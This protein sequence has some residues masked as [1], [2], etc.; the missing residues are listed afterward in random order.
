MGSALS[1]SK[2]AEVF[3]KVAML[4]VFF[5]SYARNFREKRRALE[6]N[7]AENLENVP[8]VNLEREEAIVMRD[9]FDIV[10]TGTLEELQQALPSNK[11][12]R[13]AAPERETNSIHGSPAW[14]VQQGDGHANRNVVQLQIEPRNKLLPG[15]GTPAVPRR[16]GFSLAKVWRRAQQLGVYPSVQKS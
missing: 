4:G 8:E 2:M 11:E 16:C 7:I 15:S 13:K 12:Q 1:K 10:C 9:L 3:C 6:N 14:A 5:I